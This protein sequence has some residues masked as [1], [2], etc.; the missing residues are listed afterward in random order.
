MKLDNF[1]VEYL[2]EEEMLLI[3]GGE[4]GWYYLGKALRW[5]TDGLN[6]IG[7]RAKRNCHRCNS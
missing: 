5:I 6:A 3:N 1:E 2:K 7:E 4:S